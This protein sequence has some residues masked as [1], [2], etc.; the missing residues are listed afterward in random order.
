M[1]RTAQRNEF[2][3]LL[4]AFEERF[5]ARVYR[6]VKMPYSSF[7]DDLKKYGLM[8]A[9]DQLNTRL[10][11]APLGEAVEMIYKKAGVFMANKTLSQLKKTSRRRLMIGKKGGPT[12]TALSFKFFGFNEQW[13]SEILSYFRMYLLNK[14]VIKVSQTTR[15]H[16]LRVLEEATAEGWSNEQIIQRIWESPEAREEVRNRARK[17]V[18]TETVRAANYGVLLGAEKYEYE[19]QKEWL[20]VNDNRTRTSHR[21]GSGVDGEKR[22]PEERFSNGLR[23]PGDPDGPASEVINCRCRVVIIAKRDARGRLIPKQVSIAA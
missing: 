10:M 18:R 9:K 4:D 20:S 19:V 1:N 5:I 15:D 11:N 14:A 23:F 8:Y 6:A 17:I 2:N 3:A 22:D 13:V 21:H 16:I 12:P 7:T